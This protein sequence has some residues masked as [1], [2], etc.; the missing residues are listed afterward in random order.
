MSRLLLGCRMV[1]VLSPGDAAAT[2]VA[3]R[4][5]DRLFQP[6]DGAA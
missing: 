4:G 3:I 2:N 5:L 1:P 6:S